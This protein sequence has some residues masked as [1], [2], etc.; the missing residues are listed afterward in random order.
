M[1]ERIAGLKVGKS[2]A[3]G[4]ALLLL[5]I[6]AVEYYADKRGF[7]YKELIVVL[8]GLIMGVIVFGG[9]RGI[10]FGLVLWVFTL[11][12]GYRT[13]EWT[14]N[15]RIHPSEI[16]IWALFV[17]IFA[18]RKMLATSR[19]SLPWW[20]WLSLPFWVF[21][22]WPLILGDAPWDKMMNE[23]RD[24]L[25]LVP[26]MIV[27]SVVLQR[28]RYW[29]YLLVAFYVTATWIAFMGVAEYWFPGLKSMF[30][31]FMTAPKAELTVEGFARAQFSFWG[32]APATFVCALALPAALFMTSIWRNW[33]PRT[34]IL[35]AALLQLLAIYIG[36]YRSL[37]LVV[38]I[39]VLVGCTL[40]L[41]KHGFIVAL[42]FLVVAVG[43]NQF[44]PK[45]DERV[46]SGIAAFSGAPIDHSAQLRW[47]RASW[48]INDV[49]ESPFGKGWS[50]AGWV[51]SDFLQV[52]ANLGI[53]AGLIFLGGYVHTLV[54]LVRRTIKGFSSTEEVDIALSLLLSFVG[55]G[56]LLAMQGVE[57]LPQMILPVWFIW[58]LV[59]IWLRQ[60]ADAKEPVY[61]YA[62]ANLYPAAD[63]Q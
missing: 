17:C 53:I 11:G 5:S 15:L 28:Q 37:W 35:A 42:V 13:V 7:S 38:L 10:R 47:D 49:Q 8:S 34:L 40:R 44:I 62:A 63:F 18:Q 12:L 9:E 45:S 24:F 54:R 58:S 46:S 19:L 32:G 25:L 1:I 20:L 36:G 60:K 6:F 2:L 21:A 23:C 33:L 29:S 26:L 50:A 51:H 59:D 14:P 31:A 43:G 48:A 27:T 61:S 56:G 3:I 52:A 55:A 39:Q 30:P 22:W 57:V 4:S 41:K 16:L